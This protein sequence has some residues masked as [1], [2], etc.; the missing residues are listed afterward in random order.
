MIDDREKTEKD[1][2]LKRYGKYIFIFALFIGVSS[3]IFYLTYNN[4]REAMIENLNAKQMILARQAA[5]GIESFVNDHI[6]VLR[7]MAKNRHIVDFDETGKIILH[8]FYASHAGEL[9]IITRIDKNG[10]ILHPEPYDKE[11]IRQP[12]TELEVFREVERAGQV[13]V[14]DVFIN[15]RGFK[16]IIVHVP[17]FQGNAFSG[18]LAVSFPFDFIARRYVEDIRIG[19]DGYAWVISKKGV[20]LSCP[21]PGHVGNSVFD[22]CRDFP[23]I[24]SMAERMVKGEEGVATYQFNM[25]RGNILHKMTKQ[26]V[27]LPIHLGNNFWSIVVAS[28]E[29]AAVGAL[30]GFRNRL[31]LLAVIFAIG[32]GFL[33]YILFKTG[34]L[35][36]E[37]KR[38][39]RTEDALRESEEKYRLL[40]E[41]ASD[42]I[43]ST[44][45]NLN[46]VFV[47]PSIEKIQ[48]WTAEEFKSF[49]LQEIMPPDSLA[50]V[51][52]VIEEERLLEK[53][54]GADPKRTRR[55][56]IEEYRKDG[57]TVWVE[58]IAG[59]L[60]DKDEEPVGITG[61]TRDI[62]ERKRA[63]E[64]LRHSE[65]RFSKAFHI[66]PSP[67]I[68]STLDDGRYI[69]VNESFLRMLGY[70]RE[71]MIGHTAAKLNVW[72]SYDDRKKAG[73]KLSAQG[74]LR[75]EL[76]HLRNKSGDI[77]YTLLSAEIITLNNEKYVLSIFYDITDQ[78]KLENQLRQNQKMEAIGT[79]AGGIA[80]DFNN[81][82]S[83]V[84]G[85]TEMAQGEADAGEHLRHYLEQIHK[86]GERARDLVRQILAFS[87]RHEQEREPVMI[88]PI[89]REGIKLLRSSLPSTIQIVRSITTAPTLILADSTQIHQVLMNLCTNAAHAMREKG[90]ILDIQLKKEKV[91]A[92]RALHP[93]DLKAGEY[94]KLTV[95]DT[96]RGID[97]AIMERIFDP[98]FTTKGPGEGTGLGLSV[99]YGIVRDHGGAIDVES[100]P[101][102]GTAVSVYFPLKDTEE[103]LLE[104]LT[105]TT[106]GGNERILFVDDE[107]ALVELG[108]I[109]LSSMGY[110]VTS[111]TNSSEALKIFRAGS[112]D[113]NLVI[114]DMTMPDM[115]GDELAREILKLRPDIPIILCSGFSDMISEEKARE[116]GIR[117]FIMK[118]FLKKE[119]ARA[120]REVLDG[121]SP[122]NKAL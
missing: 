96:G 40:A 115:R 70:L 32:M 4:V 25:V 90:G 5:R 43:W 117:R 22:N 18:T 76:L 95:S 9:S 68:I 93:F 85:Y 16:T 59:F 23:D 19:Q 87:R 42:V 81:I 80:H 112:R 8:D 3:F 73:Q 53:E 82:L 79:L 84:I 109:M 107:P 94:V 38:R 102:R 98:F 28:P 118:P 103:P 10:N 27:F 63:E 120:I 54:A 39:Q 116:L 20:E 119:M 44:D 51:G 88:A 12:V 72:A 21:V 36:D 60:R 69:D 48:G 46:F 74:F 1:K 49:R 83:A 24:L 67:T 17:V 47:S 2:F 7:H 86:A 55:L 30:Q 105:E 111:S 33:F 110:R 62:S 101:G 26:A 61:I 11:A 52:K 97:P 66:S 65:E 104:Q 35:T 15:R 114:T 92:A 113:F 37:I 41:N 99:V 121:E 106:L 14:S 89:I 29:E 100:D 122:Q 58:V 31:L 13:A 56:E 64:A 78:R 77:R 45:L 91:V 108:G 71:E 75:G 6:V 50:M 57:S 34:I